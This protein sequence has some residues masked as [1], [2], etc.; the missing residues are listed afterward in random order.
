MNEHDMKIGQI[1]AVIYAA[2]EVISRTSFHDRGTELMAKETA[3][4][5]IK[6]IM[7]DRQEGSEK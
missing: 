1:N 4:D 5:H 3:Y 6:Q 2:E 7:S